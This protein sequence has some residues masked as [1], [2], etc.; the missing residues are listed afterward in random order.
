M[1]GGNREVKQV[2][3]QEPFVQDELDFYSDAFVHLEKNVRGWMGSKSGRDSD[4]DV[5]ESVSELGGGHLDRVGIRFDQD[6]HL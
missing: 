4:N 2:P 6:P 1:K 3:E 5:V